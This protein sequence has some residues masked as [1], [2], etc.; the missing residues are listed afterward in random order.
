M[1]E[2]EK[3]GRLEQFE[4]LCSER[5]IPCT[6]QRRVILEAVLDH[7]DHPTANQV[8]TDV[9]ASH[10]GI[11][12]A[13]VHRTLEILSRLGIITKTCHPGK[14][15][16]YDACT[17]IHHHLIC[18]HCDKVVDFHD[19]G[20]NSLKVPDTSSTG[21]EISDFRVQLRGICRECRDKQD[22]KD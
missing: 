20:L 13:T 9:S 17:D 5:G 7:G 14:V 10:R 19:E 21:F 11:S 2:R 16:R 15:A 18:L 6:V 12:R 3:K 1:D 8:F 22:E 4:L